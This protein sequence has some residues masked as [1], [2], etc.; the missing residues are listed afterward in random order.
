MVDTLVNPDPSTLPGL[1]A[2]LLTEAG[3]SAATTAIIALVIWGWQR[4]N[5]VALSDGAKTAL[6]FL[7]P[8]GLV[9]VGY[10]GLVALGQERWSLERLYEVLY[11]L[12]LA[13]IGSQGFFHF[14]WNPIGHKL[15]A[16]PT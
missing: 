8:V 12:I 16:Q 10:F 6:A 13:L 14:I 1:F 9:L 7:I 2:W 3:W 4:L 11:T 5:G 15:E